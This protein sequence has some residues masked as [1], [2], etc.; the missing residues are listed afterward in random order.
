MKSGRETNL[1]AGRS[2]SSTLVSIVLRQKRAFLA[3]RVV[4]EVAAS[5][6]KISDRCWERYISFAC[7]TIARSGVY[8]CGCRHSGKHIY[9]A[10]EWRRQIKR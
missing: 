10:E 6:R 7:F 8:G 5:R 9:N 1:V 4:R 2:A 3:Q